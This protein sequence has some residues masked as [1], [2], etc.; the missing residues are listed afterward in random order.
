MLKAFPSF[1]SIYR[2]NVT[3]AFYAPDTNAKGLSHEKSEFSANV[4]N[5]LALNQYSS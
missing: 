3:V 5:Q 1:N 2:F 4:Q